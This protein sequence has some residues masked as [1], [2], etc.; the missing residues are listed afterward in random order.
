MIQFITFFCLIIIFVF[1]SSSAFYSS[2]FDSTTIYSFSIQPYINV[3]EICVSRGVFK[4]AGDSGSSRLALDLVKCVKR[5]FSDLQIQFSAETLGEVNLFPEIQI[6]MLIIYYYWKPVLQ[7]LCARCLESPWLCLWCGYRDLCCQS[8][9][10]SAPIVSHDSCFPPEGDRAVWARGELTYSMLGQGVWW[11]G[12]RM[13][14]FLHVWAYFSHT[15]ST[16]CRLS[17][18]GGDG[19]P[20]FRGCRVFNGYGGGKWSRC[21]WVLRPGSAKILAAFLNFKHV[22]SL[23]ESSSQLNVSICNMLNCR[24]CSFSY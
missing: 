18:P 10:G 12:D 21:S 3:G 9:L 16:P 4:M 17:R 22:S 13:G 23:H 5:S 2:C 24:L 20:R 6:V 7:T 19:A 14:E 15:V 8:A 1:D 11:W